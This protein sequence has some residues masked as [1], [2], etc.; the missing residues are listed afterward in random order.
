MLRVPPGKTLPLIAD[1]TLWTVLGLD[2]QLAPSKK[3]GRLL[4][5]AQ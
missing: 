5:R 1:H 3:T 2:S 4:V